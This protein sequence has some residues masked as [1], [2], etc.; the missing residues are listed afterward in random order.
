[1]LIIPIREHSFSLAQ[2]FLEANEEKCVFLSSLVR[3]H[4]KDLYFVLDLQDNDINFLS[5][6]EILPVYNQII[7]VFY[8]HNTLFHFFSDIDVFE[9]PLFEKK[10]TDFIVSNNLKIK[11]ISGEMQSSQK[12]L[13]VIAAVDGK[14]PYQINNYKLMS[15][16]KSDKNNLSAS[17]LLFNDDEIIR[18][19]QND[20]DS[21]FLLEQKYMIEEVLPVGRNI[22]QIEVSVSLKQILKN[23]LCLAL[24]SDGEI[25]SK[26]NTNAIGQNWIQLGGIYTLPQFR[27]NGYAKQTVSALCRRIFNAGKNVVLF[28]KEKNLPAK[29][30]YNSLG[31]AEAGDYCIGYFN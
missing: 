15:L 9:N 17:N 5:Q 26:A 4:S 30:L 21:L 28:V 1:M 12:L 27:Q 3:R 22:T 13:K 11:C 6:S 2:K 31:F 23:Q 20:F 24:L 29:A 18:C 19:T 8:L 10:F 16:K 14:M 25:V 7:G